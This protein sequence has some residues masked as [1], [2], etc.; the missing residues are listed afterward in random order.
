[1]DNIRNR[2]TMDM[3]RPRFVCV[4]SSYI[5]ARFSMLIN[6]PVLWWINPRDDPWRKRAMMFGMIWS[7]M[8]CIHKQAQ[9]ILKISYVSASSSLGSQTRQVWRIP[10]L[11][12][13]NIGLH[14]VKLL[15]SVRKA[16]Q[17]QPHALSESCSDPVTWTVRKAAQI[18]YWC[19]SISLSTQLNSIQFLKL[20]AED[21]LVDKNGCAKLLPTDIKLKVATSSSSN[22]LIFVQLR[23]IFSNI[24]FKY[25]FLCLRIKFCHVRFIIQILWYQFVKN[26]FK[27][28]NKHQLILH[29]HC[30]KVIILS[31]TVLNLRYW[32]AKTLEFQ[33]VLFPVIFYFCDSISGTA[34]VLNI[35][36]FQFQLFKFRFLRFSFVFLLLTQSVTSFCCAVSDM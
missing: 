1:M 36:Q 29:S 31:C 5:M 35:F 28:I 24:H 3:S 22:F 10:N 33:F 21:T 30:H 2:E 15:R 12:F 20:I 8:N 26:F 23:H 7:E 27:A 19:Q 25:N 14:Q 17:I 13:S 4:Y 6:P 18:H 16:A 32:S 34:L 9:P 11:M